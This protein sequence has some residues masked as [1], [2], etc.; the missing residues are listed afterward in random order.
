MTK[1]GVVVAVAP[2][3][4]SRMKASPC[5]YADEHLPAHARMFDGWS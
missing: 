5:R 1:E 3:G 4:Q 2:E